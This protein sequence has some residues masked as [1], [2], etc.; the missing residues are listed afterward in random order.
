MPLAITDRIYLQIRINNVEIPLDQNTI[1][2]LHIVE[3]VRIYVPMLSFKINDIT[4]FL[5]RNDLLVDG[6]LIEITIE[7][8]G[9]RTVYVFRL[10]GSSELIAN[11]ATSYI[12]K[13]Y[14]NVPRYWT[15]SSVESLKGSASK[16][17]Q[18]IASAVNLTYTGVTTTEDQLWVP[19]NRKYC[20]FAKAIVDGASISGTS[21][22]KLAVTADKEMLVR[23]IST[24]LQ[25]E[26]K[27]LF[28]NKDSSAESALIITDYE[29]LNKSGFFNASTGYK[30]FKI[31]QSV[32]ADDIQ[33]KDV[34]FNKNSRKM[35]INKGIQAGVEQNRVAFAPID[36]GNVSSTYESAKYQ[37]RRLSNLFVFGLN[38][39]TPR[40][41]K[42]KL[43]DVV[44]TE[45]SKPDLDGVSQYS[46]K[47]LLT[48]K[49]TYI[50]GMNFFHKCEVYRHGLNAIKDSTQ[51]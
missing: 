31:M 11:G 13:G 44:G 14:L 28:S 20:D 48:S 2:Y 16:S 7:I 26:P 40:P 4:K 8:E 25:A 6:S 34:S 36:V 33:I 41:V 12:I 43:L 49:V 22:I 51:I 27:E 29:A 3:S 17:L 9:Y 1:S 46:G 47:Y 21:C 42:S 18:A 35:M 24:A 37:N 32:L 5:T 45:I 30:D 15:Q 39:L 19:M 38:F 50:H 10:F 23:D